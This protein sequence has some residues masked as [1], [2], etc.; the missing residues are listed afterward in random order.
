MT[1]EG[2]GRRGMVRPRARHTHS[3]PILTRGTVPIPAL[4]H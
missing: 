2:P 4:S 3:T 1:R